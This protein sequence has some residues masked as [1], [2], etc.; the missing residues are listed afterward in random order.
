MLSFRKHYQQRSPNQKPLL[1]V[2]WSGLRLRHSLILKEFLHL[3]DVIGH[4]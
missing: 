4:A 3:I 1:K 2:F